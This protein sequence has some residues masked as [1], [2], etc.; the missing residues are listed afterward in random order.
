MK[1]DIKSLWVNGL[2]SDRFRQG[3]GA[4]QVNTQDGP[5]HCCLGVLCMLAIEAGIAVSTEMRG[6]GVLPTSVMEWA[7]LDT[8]DPYIE[9]AT[10]AEHND[11]ISV[12]RHDFNE[13]ADLIEANL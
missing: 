4:L 8:R 5:K 7:G 11:G 13:I 9:G 10:L 12:R 1:A 3:K 2:R 6:S